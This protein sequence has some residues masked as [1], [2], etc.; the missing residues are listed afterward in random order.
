[1]LSAASHYVHIT[2]ALSQKAIKPNDATNKNYAED[3]MIVYIWMTVG[4]N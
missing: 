4:N 3:M 1:M 2:L